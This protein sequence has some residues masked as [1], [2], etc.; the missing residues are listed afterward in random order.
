M[1]RIEGH[2]KLVLA[3]DDNGTVRDAS[4]PSTTL[5]RGFEYLVRGRPPEFTI[6]VVERICGICPIPH[7]VASAEAFE[8][9]IG[10]SIPP[11]AH[12]LRELLLIS[13]RLHSH[14]LHQ[15]L[16]AH[17]FP[18]PGV[19]KEEMRMRLQT[20]RR[21]AQEIADIVGGEAIH[22]SNIVIGGMKTQISARATALLYR[23]MRACEPL[24]R[25][26]R[27]DIAAGIEAW[28][29]ASAYDISG[30]E[31]PMLASDMYYGD[32]K[33]VDL[34]A[35]SEMSPYR[36]Y[37]KDDAGRSSNITIPLYYGEPVEVGPRA[38]LAKYKGLKST[39]PLD[40]NNARAREMAIYVNR[41]LE[42]LDELDESR[43]VRSD[44]ILCKGEGVGV[45]EAPRGTNIHQAELG[46]NGL[47][48]SYNIIAP[49]TWNMPAIERAIVGNHQSCAEMIV[50]SFDPCVDCATHCIE[51]KDMEG[52]HIE[53]RRSL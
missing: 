8:H 4:F 46:K 38:R 39:S 32:R 37:G 10:V 45:I 14:A 7:G 9:A 11:E 23:S 20:I 2:A 6:K 12:R 40:I 43:I 22:P 34:S 5:V 31:G 33:E 21:G 51:V 1:T 24:V 47:V 41:A 25:Q 28:K 15:Y 29:D 3:V 27:D 53:T 18:I 13:D 44:A 48:E 30:K 50:R 35:I 19:K 49:T 52:C 42:I 17:D 26:N 36:Y 16:L